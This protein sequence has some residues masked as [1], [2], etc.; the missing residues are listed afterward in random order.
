M[1]CSERLRDT[2]VIRVQPLVKGFMHRFPPEALKEI[3]RHE[4]DVFFRF[5]FNIL[6]GNVLKAARYGVWNRYHHDDKDFY[7][8]GP[9]LFWRSTKIA[10]LR[11]SSCR[12]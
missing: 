1:D 2:P 4:I 3:R 7:R 11:V 6:R 8:G 9:A 5:G 10:R 12:Y